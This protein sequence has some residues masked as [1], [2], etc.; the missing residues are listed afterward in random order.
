MRPIS[1][2]CSAHLRENTLNDGAT[3]VSNDTMVQSI[4]L[5]SSVVLK[6]AVFFNAL[7]H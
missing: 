6:R 3:K 7:V 4:G 1:P 2:N 5:R